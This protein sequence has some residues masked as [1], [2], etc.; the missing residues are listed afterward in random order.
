MVVLNLAREQQALGMRP[1]AAGLSHGGEV[2]G[3]LSRLGVPVE[4]LQKPEGITLGLVPKLRGLIRQ[5]GIK[6]VH[7]H[8][9]GA[10]LYAGLAAHWAGIP[11][12]GTRHSARRPG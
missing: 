12:V 2:A 3:E 10:M 8:N 7:A 9:Q 6:L 11:M 5:W 1:M 4:V